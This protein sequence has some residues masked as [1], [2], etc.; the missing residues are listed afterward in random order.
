MLDDGKLSPEE[1]QEKLRQLG[2]RLEHMGLSLPGQV[3]RLDL[4]RLVSYFH[5]SEYFASLSD[6]GD[7]CPWQGLRDEFQDSEIMRILLQTAVAVRFIGSGHADQMRKQKDW[8]EGSV[9]KIYKRVNEADS[10]PLPLREACN[11]IIHAK[12]IVLESNGSGN[13]YTHFIKP[14]IFCYDD[15]EQ[16]T[17]W[18]AEIEL[19]PFV[20]LCDAV[21]QQFA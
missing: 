14:R 9:G 1:S 6:G 4:Y 8:L 2:L 15:F 20:E 7:F 13:P 18:K 12:N 16:K 17:G 19:L 3:L 11:K 21:A 5:T 10:E